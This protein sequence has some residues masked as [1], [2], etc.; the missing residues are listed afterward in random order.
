MSRIVFINQPSV[1]HLNTLLSIAIKMKSDG[2]DVR[3]FVP[4]IRLFK[5]G[6]QVFDTAID[7]LSRIERN[8]IP[9]DLLPPHL[10]HIWNA[11]FLPFKTGYNE[12]S[13]AFSMFFDG[14]EHYTHHIL[15]LIEVHTPDVLVTDFAFP[16]TS[17][18]AD[19]LNIPYVTIYHSG[20]PFRGTVV[21]PFGSGLP[22]GDVS[23]DIFKEYS[24]RENQF[25][26]RL[27]KRYN[28]ARKRYGLQ[29][30]EPDL[31]RRPYSPWLNLIASADII[32]VPRNN[33]TESTFFI[34]PC[35][36]KRIEENFDY[37]QLR[38]DKFKIY[39]SLGTVFNNKPEVFRQIIR[40][41]DNPN[42]QVIVSAGGAYQKLIRSEL[43]Q[44]TKV[45]RSV[46]QTNLLPKIDLFI[47]HGGNNSINEALYSGKPII[48]MPVGGEQADNASKIVFLGVGKRIDLFSFSE[49]Q[50]Q[51][52]VEEIWTSNNFKERAISIM[53]SLKLT[54]G[55]STAA[56]CIEWLAREQK[57][58]K[59]ISPHLTITKESVREL[60][61]CGSS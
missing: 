35:L 33:L 16:A 49:K 32:E 13:H 25:L 6:I 47:S 2:H 34:G 29:S 7:I 51:E 61:V 48:V 28:L 27:D 53:E 39:V 46:P 31:L 8:G 57:P 60:L 30:V 42:Y 3:F 17:I 37:D 40:G 56:K 15:K 43:A 12:T 10:S 23:S 58:I 5:V 18:A 38:Q 52:S 1:G 44:N 22:I 11:F 59:S 41:L 4:S 24:S 9:V 19:I 20:L 50:L 36:G 14:L 54:D 21:P 26:N 55:T 45:F